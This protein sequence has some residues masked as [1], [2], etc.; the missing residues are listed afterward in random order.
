[1]IQSISLLLLLS[2]TTSM[3]FA[4]DINTTNYSQIKQQDV[5]LNLF[6]KKEVLNL[7]AAELSKSIPQ[8]IDEYTT[9]VEIKSDN[10]TLV[11]IY[12]IYTGAKSDE[13]IQKEDHQ[14]MREAVTIGSCKTSQ[15]FLQSGI[16]IRYFYRSAKSKQK[17]FVFNINQEDCH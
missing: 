9:L 5:D 4:K 7:A 11:Y 6:K 13:A 1:M 14:R 16:S 12:E 3:A 15:R 2:L 8:K 17:L 10:L